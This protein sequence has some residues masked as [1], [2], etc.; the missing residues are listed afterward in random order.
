MNRFYLFCAFVTASLTIHSQNC[1]NSNFEEGDSDGYTLYSGQLVDGMPDI[2]IIGFQ[3]ERHEIM[4][5]LDGY[6]PEA[7]FWCMENDSIPV[8]PPSGGAYSMRLGNS[9]TGAQAERVTLEFVVTPDVSFF[10]LQYAVILQDPGHNFEDQPRFELRIFD[11]NDEQVECGLYTVRSGPNIPGFENCGPLRVRPWTTVGI[12][13]QSYLGQNIKIEILTTDCGLGGHY[14][15]AYFDAT[16]K[17]LTIEVVG[18]CEGADS[19]VVRVTEGFIDYLW[20]TGDTTSSIVDHDPQEGEIYQVTVT[21]ATGC[22]LIL[23]DTLPSIDEEP[24][25]QFLGPFDSTYCG[26]PLNFQFTPNV[27][28][29]QE[30]F[31]IYHGYSA[32]FFLIDPNLNEIYGFYAYNI[33]GCISDTVYYTFDNQSPYPEISI[34]PVDCPQDTTGAI[35]ISEGPDD[36]S[37]TYIWEDGSTGDSLINLSY[38]E[39]YVTISEAGGCD[40]PF[41]IEVPEPDALQ[42]SASYPQEVCEFDQSGFISIY[43]FGGTPPYQ[44]SIDS[45]QSFQNFNSFNQLGPGEYHLV[46]MDQAGCL[47]EDSIFID[48]ILSPIFLDTSIYET[49]DSFVLF[50]P[51]VQFHDLIYSIHHFSYDSVFE[52]NTTEES[53]YIFI[54]SNQECET[55]DTFYFVHL[56]PRPEDSLVHNRCFGDSLG[57]IFL[58]IPEGDSLYE[59][60]W[61]DSSKL[62][63]LIELQSG[64]Y[65]VTVS[66]SLGCEIY[67]YYSILEP[68]KIEIDILYHNKELCEGDTSGAFEIVVAGGT[69]PCSFS[70]D[71]GQNFVQEFFFDSLLAGSYFIEVMDSLGCIQ[72]SRAQIDSVLYP[73]FLDSSVIIVCDSIFYFEPS[74]ENYIEVY[75]IHHNSTEDSVLIKLSEGNIYDFIASNYD[76]CFS[77]TFRVE[78]IQYPEPMIQ[79]ELNDLRCKDTMD[80]SIHVKSLNDTSSYSYVWNTG[81]MDTFISMLD[82]GLF[83]LEVTDTNNCSWNYQF[84]LSEP[85]PLLTEYEYIE[86]YV[87]LNEYTGVLE[88]N[89]SGGTEPYQHSIDG[90]VSFSSNVILDSLGAGLHELI[91]IDSHQCAHT[92]MFEILIDSS[93]IW[94]APHITGESCDL[95]NA[96][97]VLSDISGGFGE[98]EFSLDKENW[99]MDHIFDSL[100]SGN[101]VVYLRDSLGC[102][103]SLDLVTPYLEPIRID[104]I[105]VQRTSCEL[106]NGEVE[107]HTNHEFKVQYGLDGVYRPNALFNN[108]ASGEYSIAVV[109]SNGCF[110]SSLVNIQTSNLP[111]ITKIDLSYEA[112]E[113]RMASLGI[114]ANSEFLP[115]L[116]SLDG[117]NYSEHPRFDSLTEGAHRIHIIDQDGCRIFEDIRISLPSPLKIDYQLLTNP[118]CGP[119]GRIQVEASGGVSPISYQLDS[120]MINFDGVFENLVA[121]GYVVVVKDSSDC[122][123]EVFTTLEYECDIYI[124]NVFSPN[125]DGFND[126]FRV[127]VR[128]DMNATITDMQIFNRWG[129]LVHHMNQINTNRSEAF[130]DGK[131]E[132]KLSPNGTYSYIIS[133]KFEQ[134]PDVYRQ[135]EVTLIR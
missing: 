118:T 105:H 43:A 58:H 64:Q 51:N 102:L 132:G 19:A 129:D 66:N 14:G 70:I 48:S 56:G 55:R 119:D 82:V 25:P 97:I 34:I 9:M 130:W 111:Y 131:H 21:S 32:D 96:S 16:C 124:P 76:S 42:I 29:S 123:I 126:E 78:F 84:I 59:Y 77:D 85:S 72:N 91:T 11:E 107:I 50:E 63:S 89:T 113:A 87:C 117:V 71:S 92:T 1:F 30:I 53:Q 20:N 61:Q 47:A 7:L 65:H 75:S 33:Y 90:G 41:V 99:Q 5:V 128:P 79:V 116:Y 115:V 112:C 57:K 81:S 98:Y 121:G 12:E 88:L 49:C 17:P 44:Y 120:V 8:V 100:S 37:Y 15:Y 4:H 35:Y 134:G 31:S 27:L 3:P 83:R 104:S 108:L 86:K 54:A 28:N 26:D 45:G 109:D 122:I 127:Y 40:A 39:Y 95:Q 114:E 18:Y 23:S 74:I 22:E 103:D 10:L 52:I 24:L 6:D 69:P 2:N 62:D 106:E 67:P 110:D 80:G 93:F 94:S 38:G 135:G 46:V 60:S 101:Y 36:S 73:V 13:L 68:P 133:M 125:G